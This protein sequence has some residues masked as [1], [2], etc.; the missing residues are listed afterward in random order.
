VLARAVNM[1]EAQQQNRSDLGS[2]MIVLTHFGTYIS[3]SHV[4]EDILILFSN[5]PE[6]LVHLY[7]RSRSS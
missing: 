5:V 7:P 4:E 6:S 2:T 1:L 3:C